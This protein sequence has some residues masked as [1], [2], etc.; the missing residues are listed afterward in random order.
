MKGK[1]KEGQE[2]QDNYLHCQLDGIWSHLGC[3]RRSL[4][5]ER[6]LTLS[7]GEHHPVG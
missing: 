6:G 7:V 3:Y 4:T 1:G 2:K 5:K